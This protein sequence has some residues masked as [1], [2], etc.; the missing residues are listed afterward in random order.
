MWT[1]KAAGSEL[2]K[3]P[4]RIKHCVGS[5]ALPEAGEQVAPG[6]TEGPLQD[7][8]DRR[9]GK[10]KAGFKAEECLLQPRH[11]LRLAEDRP[12]ERFYS[13]PEDHVLH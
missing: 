12:I 10:L 3:S 9:R 6:S 8:R 1:S 4:Q 7:M 2:I 5:V 11:V 13:G